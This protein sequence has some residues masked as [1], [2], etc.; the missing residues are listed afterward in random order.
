[1]NNNQDNSISNQIVINVPTEYEKPVMA[2]RLTDSRYCNEF[3]HQ[4]KI[5]LSD[6][7]TWRDK[8]SCSY[9]Q[10]DR[11]EGCFCK[12]FEDQDKIFSLIGI[13][14]KKTL[15]DNCYRYFYDCGAVLGLCFYGILLSSF[16]E[17]YLT[18]WGTKQKRFAVSAKYFSEFYPDLTMEQ[19]K[20]M[21]ID[22]RPAI[23]FIYDFFRL[24]DL[25]K[26]ELL[27][28]GFTNEEIFIGPVFYCDK[29]R[30]FIVN[31]NHPLEYFLKDRE[32]CEQHEFRI[33]IS[34]NNREL[35]GVLKQNNNDIVIGDVS[36]IAT[37]QNFYFEEF[38]L[39][40]EGSTLI[41]KLSESQTTHIRD[42]NFEELASLILQIELNLLPQGKLDEKEQNE[43]LDNM[44]K[45][46]YEKY[47]ITYQK[48]SAIFGHIE[49]K[50]YDMLPEWYRKQRPFFAYPKEITELF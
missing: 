31:M 16:S 44:A 41:Y 38:D 29:T 6:S 4:G 30:P 33:I 11:D 12:S 9:G 2:L 21:E 49:K 18:P 40:I 43:A 7:E 34:S 14:Y 37:V 5:H 17:K 15:E 26:K 19:Y 47:G 48:K 27:R 22:K 42:M 24:T 45:I 32:F 20:R 28:L 46:M 50:Q 13:E 23:V 25:I 10:L 36:N 35:L 3:V 8:T 39:A 1:M